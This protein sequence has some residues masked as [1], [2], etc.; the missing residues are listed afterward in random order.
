MRS[1]LERHFS[2]ITLA[3]GRIPPDETVASVLAFCVFLKAAARGSL[4]FFPDLPMEHWAFYGKVVRKLVAAGELQSGAQ[5]QFDTAFSKSL[6]RLA[7]FA[8]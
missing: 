8:T 6:L 1:A 7:A 3:K 5:D 2:D 4:A